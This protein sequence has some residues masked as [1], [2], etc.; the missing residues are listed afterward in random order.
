MRVRDELVDHHPL[1]QQRADGAASVMGVARHASGTIGA[2]LGEWI[3]S[4]ELIA[5]RPRGPRKAI[6][7]KIQPSTVCRLMGNQEMN[8]WI[9][10]NN[11]LTSAM[12]AMNEISI[13]I[14]LSIKKRPSLVPRAAASSTL[15]SVRGMST[16]TPPRVSGTSV[17]GSMIFAIMIVP[18]AVMMTAVSKCPASI[19]NARYRAMIEA[20]PFTAATVI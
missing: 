13:A 8:P 5:Y 18:G 7:R 12:S 6:G 4:S 3:A 14:T 9:H 10:P 17:S 15:T 20:V 11:P 19:P 1:T 16:L 2:L